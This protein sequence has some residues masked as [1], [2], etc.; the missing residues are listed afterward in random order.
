MLI[1]LAI[2]G[3]ATALGAKISATQVLDNAAGR[4]HKSGG[5]VASYTVKGSGNK[6]GVRGTLKVKGSKFAILDNNVSTW[7][8]GAT[9]WNYNVHSDECTVSTPTVSEI[10]QINPYALL[11]G[12]KTLY[13]ASMAK[14]KI[15]GTYA[16]KMTP[17]SRQNP[18]KSAVLYV[19]ATDWQPVRIDL[20][21]RQN[22]TVTIL[23]TSI[24]T[25]QKLSDSAFTFPKSKY[26]KAE[27][28]DLR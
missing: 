3:S 5:I 9:Q 6:V 20:A 23:I 16:V 28:I 27:I 22:Q 18:V 17:V 8:D 11:T 24:K 21:D 2:F 4:L 15:F 25:G 14:S 13:K 12:Y 26:P 10:S 7:Y 1:S 19:R